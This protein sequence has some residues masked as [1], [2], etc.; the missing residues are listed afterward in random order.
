[1]LASLKLAELMGQL[2]EKI[3]KRRSPSRERERDA[4][5]KADIPKLNDSHLRDYP[6]LTEEDDAQKW[7]LGFL[8]M[9]RPLE[10]S[11]AE[12][13]EVLAT[14]LSVRAVSVWSVLSRLIPFKQRMFALI[15]GLTNRSLIS[16]QEELDPDLIVHKE[17]ETGISFINKL[18]RTDFAQG[19]SEADL[20]AAL[21]VKLHVQYRTELQYIKDVHTLEHLQHEVGKLDQTFYMNKKSVN[22]FQIKA[23]TKGA[24]Y[25]C[26]LQGHR[27]FECPN[28]PTEP[29]HRNTTRNPRHT[30]SMVGEEEGAA[31]QDGA[32]VGSGA[33]D[34]A[35]V[36]KATT[37]NNSQTE[38]AGATEEAREVGDAAQEEE[39]AITRGQK[40]V[41]RTNQRLTSLRPIPST[42]STTSMTRR[43][44]KATP[45]TRRRSGAK[46]RRRRRS[47]RRR[48]ATELTEGLS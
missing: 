25:T 30:G 48:R 45:P 26:G 9:I 41:R 10:L 40:G 34:G 8:N 27:A 7:V 42:G 46:N 19:R 38:A 15:S 16:I 6:V 28:S 39:V 43:R 23:P 29:K 11:E 37:S 5:K 44:R 21:K 22:A 20:V 18:L 17:G 1:M 31:G 2:A 13:E 35:A 33:E 4:K 36:G 47:R 24:C 14:K 3:N 32:E 12:K